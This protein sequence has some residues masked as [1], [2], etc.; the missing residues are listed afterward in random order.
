M[1]PEPGAGAA[2]LP[3]LAATQLP[4]RMAA[5]LAAAYNLSQQA[6]VAACL[7][8]YAAPHRPFSLVQG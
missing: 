3:R 1:E 8:P 4:Q 7:E 5:A 2:G 6:A